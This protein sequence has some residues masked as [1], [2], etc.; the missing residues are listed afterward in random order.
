MKKIKLT[1]RQYAEIC[2]FSTA[3]YKCP[4]AE[5]EAEDGFPLGPSTQMSKVR[6]GRGHCISMWERKKRKKRVS[7]GEG[8][9]GKAGRGLHISMEGEEVLE[10]EEEALLSLWES[11]EEAEAEEETFVFLWEEEEADG[12]E[13]ALVFLL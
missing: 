2:L 7:R 9:V 3:Q 1:V 11:E 5:L 13:G 10:E 8:R 12:K 6:R 4:V